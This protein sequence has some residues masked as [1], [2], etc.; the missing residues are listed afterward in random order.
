MKK[1]QLGVLLLLLG[2][3]VRGQ[4][5]DLPPR[6]PTA[7]KGREFARSIAA[8]ALK[9]REERIRAEIEAGNVPAFLR[10]LVP[11]TV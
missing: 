4:T 11:V 7:P 5:L 2:T 9:D 3:A 8:L 1:S 6:S 10:K